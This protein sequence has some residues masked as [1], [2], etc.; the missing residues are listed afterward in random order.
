MLDSG[1]LDTRPRQV[2]RVLFSVN[3]GVCSFSASIV[4]VY[5]GISLWITP[6]RATAPSL[7]GIADILPLKENHNL[8]IQT[9][10]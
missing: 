7:K 3:E 4:Y 9:Q 2:S 6:D 10:S 1:T 8:F 5:V